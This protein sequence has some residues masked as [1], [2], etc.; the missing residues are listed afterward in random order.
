MC[1]DRTQNP[2]PCLPF[3][4]LLHQNS[5]SEQKLESAG[6]NISFDIV[7]LVGGVVELLDEIGVDQLDN[8][9]V[10]HVAEHYVKIGVKLFN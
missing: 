8:I 4:A 3:F 7:E 10:K 1:K 2:F 6:E 5:V 9:V